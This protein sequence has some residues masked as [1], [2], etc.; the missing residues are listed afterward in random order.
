MKVCDYLDS[1]I[2]FEIVKTGTYPEKLQLSEKSIRKLE[3][4]LE[5]IQTNTEERYSSW[6]DIKTNDLL[7][8]YKGIPIEVV[9]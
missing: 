8:N 2:D 6:W 1:V 9:I 7:N 4:E 3:Q 5:T